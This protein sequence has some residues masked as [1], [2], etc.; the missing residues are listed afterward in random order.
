MVR[1]STDLNTISI[2]TFSALQHVRLHM[3]APVRQHV[4]RRSG[5]DLFKADYITTSVSVWKK[6]LFALPMVL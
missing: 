6:D 3:N 4:M 1:L 2:K 5:R